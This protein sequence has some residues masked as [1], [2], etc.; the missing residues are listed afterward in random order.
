MH[1]FNDLKTHFFNKNLRSLRNFTELSQV[2]KYQL[3]FIDITNNLSSYK[4][5][6]GMFFCRLMINVFIDTELKA[7]IINYIM[8]FYCSKI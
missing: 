2:H 5:K 1:I 6:K 7:L 3:Y 4:V 8:I